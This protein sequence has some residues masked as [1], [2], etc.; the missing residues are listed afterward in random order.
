MEKELWQRNSKEINEAKARRVGERTVAETL[1]TRE[2]IPPVGS[3]SK[4]L[5]PIGD[6]V[7]C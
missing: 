1:N 2:Y 4:S 7:D 6:L 3:G 5:P